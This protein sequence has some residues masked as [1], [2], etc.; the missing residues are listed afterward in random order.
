MIFPLSLMKETMRAFRSERTY[1]AC[2]M[3]QYEAGT[4]RTM[5]RNRHGEYFDTSKIAL[6]TARWR[7]AELDKMIADFQGLCG[8][9][10]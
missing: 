2:V 9:A 4:L 7:V 8:E 6:A 3:Q 10:V 1:W 5:E